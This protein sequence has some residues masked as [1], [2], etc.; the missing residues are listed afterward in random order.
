VLLGIRDRTTLPLDFEVSAVRDTGLPILLLMTRESLTSCFDRR[1]FLFE[2][3]PLLLLELES[4]FEGGGDSGCGFGGGST[5]LVV[6][7]SVLGFG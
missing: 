6:R 1:V 2:L 4:V 7:R 5:D 3:S